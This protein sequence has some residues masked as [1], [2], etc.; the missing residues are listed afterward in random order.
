[1][2]K[3][4]NVALY[5]T[6][7]IAAYK[8]LVMTRLLVKAGAN[9][10]V[11]MTDGALE[12][13]QPLSFQALSKHSVIT[14]HSAGMDADQITHIEVA[15][16]TDLAVVMPADA[17]T[18]A[19][20]ANGIAD[21]VIS[22]TLLATDSQKLVVPA[23]NDHM[24]AN[25]ATQ[26]NLATIKQDG[27]AIIAP[28]IGFLAEGYAAPGRMVE[29]ELVM[30]RIQT[31]VK[32]KQTPPTH[33]LRGRRVLVTAGATRQPIDPVR[34]ITNA[35]SGKMGVSVAKA[36]ADLGA[37]VTLICA[38]VRVSIPAGIK[39]VNVVTSSE[40]QAAV[41]QLMKTNDVLIMTAAVADFQ[42]V[43]VQPQKI[44]KAAQ[45][46]TFTLHFR[47][48]D[49]ILKAVAK[50][51]RSDQYTVG[52][53]AETNDLRENALKKLRSKGLDLLVA[54]DVS[55][56]QIGFSSDD[57]Q[58]TFLRTDH[59][60]IQTKVLPKPAIAE[61]LVDLVAQDLNQK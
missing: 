60:P 34:F 42:S 24:L 56:P 51:K 13:I 17:N 12:F 43:R 7:S 46:D 44:K 15:Q 36:A 41:L 55:N 54:N 2:I 23:M 1:M 53:A 50:I 19:K 10:R 32:L 48:A 16:W 45:S 18:I 22:T 38:D 9:V 29:P 30:E 35:S 5:V 3:N 57:N 4:L 8:S 11:L 14:N 58:V 6:G 26:R 28:T 59:A 39:V 33:S 40:L 31:L 47:E 37:E 61:Q 27:I 25:P 20:L 21:D 52:F 49:D